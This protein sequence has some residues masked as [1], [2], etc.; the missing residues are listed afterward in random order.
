MLVFLSIGGISASL[1][2][3]LATGLVIGFLSGLIGS[4]TGGCT[5]IF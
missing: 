2:I 5:R 1:A 4:V 3:L